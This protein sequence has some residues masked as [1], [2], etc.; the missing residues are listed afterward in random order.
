[1]ETLRDLETQI[2]IL[3]EIT[4]HELPILLPVPQPAATPDVCSKPE[5]DHLII[6][7]PC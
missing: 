5:I 1:M 2:A 3:G 4:L 7:E 6:S